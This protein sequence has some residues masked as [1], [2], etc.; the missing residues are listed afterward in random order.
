VDSERARGGSGEC[1]GRS[2][3]R[4]NGRDDQRLGC[5][6]WEAV[7]PAEWVFLFDLPMLLQFF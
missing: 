1:M 2:D 7:S 3:G 6:H 5:V 4:G